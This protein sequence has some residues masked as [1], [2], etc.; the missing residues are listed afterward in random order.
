MTPSRENH[1]F[2]AAE[3]S[4]PDQASCSYFVDK[5]FERTAEEADLMR[6][7]ILQYNLDATESDNLELGN[8]PVA[9]EWDNLLG[10]TQL[11]PIYEDVDGDDDAVLS[12][13]SEKPAEGSSIVSSTMMDPIN[14]VQPLPIGET[15]QQFVK[16]S[17]N[18]LLSDEFR[19]DG[20]GKIEFYTDEPGRFEPRKGYQM[21]VSQV[22]DV[23]AAV[24]Y[25][26]EEPMDVSQIDTKFFLRNFSHRHGKKNIPCAPTP[27]ALAIAQAELWKKHR[28][29]VSSFASND[30][31]SEENS[32]EQQTI[33]HAS[34]T[35]PAVQQNVATEESHSNTMDDRHHS[36]W[37]RRVPD[38]KKLEMPQ[39]SLAALANRMNINLPQLRLK[40]RDENLDHNQSILMSA[41]AKS[42][43][44]VA[45]PLS[46][47]FTS[48]PVQPMFDGTQ[49]L[50]AH[51]QVNLTP[52][53][54]P[55]VAE[56]DP[57]SE[58]R[59]NNISAISITNTAKR[60]PR[61]EEMIQRICDAF[62]ASPKF[63][64]NTLKDCELPPYSYK[65]RV[66]SRDFENK[67]HPIV[68][69]PEPFVNRSPLASAAKS[70]SLDTQYSDKKCT[71]SSSAS[72]KYSPDSLTEHKEVPKRP[73]THSTMTNGINDSFGWRQLSMEL[74]RTIQK[75]SE[76]I[77]EQNQ[78]LENLL[79]H[80]LNQSAALEDDARIQRELQQMSIRA[81]VGMMQAL[82]KNE[83]R[84]DHPRCEIAKF[85][86]DRAY[87][88]IFKNMF[89]EQFKHDSEATK[90]KHLR[91]LVRGEAARHINYIDGG[92]GGYAMMWRLLDKEYLPKWNVGTE[93]LIEAAKLSKPLHDD[94]ASLTE[95]YMHSRRI[96]VIMGRQNMSDDLMKSLLATLV[97]RLDPTSALQ[98]STI[99]PYMNPNDDMDIFIEYLK[100]RI[101]S[102]E[103]A[104]QLSKETTSTA[105]ATTR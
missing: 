4:S 64:G 51:S 24:V 38:V 63:N 2:L 30:S 18:G 73:E 52:S 55:K 80:Q 100:N 32:V 67:F 17:R 12:E 44:K 74:A 78:R 85:E 83:R 39:N 31:D 61:A 93:C 7:A 13:S 89:E 72:S 35:P 6:S 16:G 42:A 69:E 28:K 68:S 20:D 84:S 88:P 91:N 49:Y 56:I 5:T 46:E 66:L 27:S 29:P 10:K 82:E 34:P 43:Q 45:T 86:G 21:T 103:I 15:G 59:H 96:H 101:N 41:L 75:I 36:Q 94:I 11:F 1:E 62:S 81:Q 58:L 33:R 48:P 40:N 57:N 19:F 97:G 65:E 8:R 53:S 105:F 60:G 99:S 14:S 26:P 102:L 90:Y 37:L 95:F 23:T 71:S 92:S 76:P 77:T 104:K 98:Y 25:E 3:S 47:S 50:S 54:P 9:N 79:H 87:Y 70:S 22:D